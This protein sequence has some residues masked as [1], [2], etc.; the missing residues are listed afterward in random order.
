MLGVTSIKSSQEV[1]NLLRVNDLNFDAIIL[2][3][4]GESIGNP[5]EA[6]DS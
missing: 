5:S 2:M 6:A 4:C 3:I 1:I